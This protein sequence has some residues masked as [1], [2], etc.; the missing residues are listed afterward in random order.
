MGIRRKGIILE[1]ASW[2]GKYVEG[3]ELKGQGLN[4]EEFKVRELKTRGWFE[5]NNK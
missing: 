3:R 2:K 1:K 5:G 4:G